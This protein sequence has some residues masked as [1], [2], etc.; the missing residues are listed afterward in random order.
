MSTTMH[1][2]Q[3]SLPYEQVEFLRQRA[4][5]DGVSMAE[6]LRSLVE[7][8]AQTQERLTERDIDAV[9]QLAGIA[10]DVK[11]LIRGTPVSE[12]VDL[13][14]AEAIGDLHAPRRVARERTP[15][16]RAR[17]GRT[18]KRRGNRK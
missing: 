4:E 9:L 2:L 16:Y 7:R 5:R 6:V 11:P 8:E 1:R 12:D 10:E 18:R 15:Q 3:I 13:Y 14:M 17:A